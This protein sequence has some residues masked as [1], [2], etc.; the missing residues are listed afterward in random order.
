MAASR[1]PQPSPAS[2]P[3]MRGESDSGSG[4]STGMTRSSPAV[5]DLASQAATHDLHSRSPSLQDSATPDPVPSPLKLDAQ[6]E[7]QREGS[8]SSL[9]GS[10][11]H[12]SRPQSPIP[13]TVQ[14]AHMQQ[15]QRRP[16]LS[17]AVGS[18]RSSTERSPS[19]SSSIGKFAHRNQFRGGVMPTP[20]HSPNTP[21]TRVVRAVT[22]MPDAMRFDDVLRCKTSL[23]RAQGYARKINELARV[24][25]GLTQ[26]MVAVQYR[27]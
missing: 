11:V 10:F 4:A 6:A 23:E 12:T 14:P 27:G 18:K 26:W 20:I 13:E 3:V 8:I 16:S 19:I 2:L 22:T 5:P 1:S 15:H 9:E 21:R 24:D 7:A 17:L 25:T